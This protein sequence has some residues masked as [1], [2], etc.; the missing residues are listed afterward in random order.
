MKPLFF[1]IA[2]LI[3]LPAAASPLQEKVDALIS[4][5]V[6]LVSTDELA[7]EM[8]SGRKYLLLDTRR[9][10]EFSV[11]HLAGATWTGFENFDLKKLSGIEK[12]SAI[13]VYCSIG[14]RSE[15]IGEKLKAAGYRNVRNLYG[16]IFA[17]ANEGRAL[18]NNEGKPTK[19]VHGCDR[20]WAKLL[21]PDVPKTLPK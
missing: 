4:R 19:T 15:K 8:K 20:R 17:W 7:G 2:L 1:A 18:E 3:H 5:S 16:G 21:D 9:K 11:S 10:E 13:V 14:Y 12:S 6:P